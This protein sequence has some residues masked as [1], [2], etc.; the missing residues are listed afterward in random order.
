MFEKKEA[1]ILA[2]R[3]NWKKTMGRGHQHISLP[4]SSSSLMCCVVA[5]PV[6]C[7]CGR[8]WNRDRGNLSV[9][10]LFFI[11]IVVLSSCLSSENMAVSR[12]LCR[13]PMMV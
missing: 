7:C 8:F 5:P 2:E 11:V 9:V 1:V 12:T 13:F 10:V 6:T 3:T 4:R